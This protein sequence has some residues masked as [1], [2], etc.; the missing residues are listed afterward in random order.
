MSN[1]Q[2]EKVVREFVNFVK[3]WVRGHKAEEW[4]GI[5]IDS[6]ESFME[7]RLEEFLDWE[8]EEKVKTISRS[9][10]ESTL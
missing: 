4:S 8:L 5:L 1:E 10:Q 9:K 2:K 7:N 3:H 6:H